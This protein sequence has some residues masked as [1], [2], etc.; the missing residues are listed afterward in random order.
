MP[1]ISPVAIYPAANIIIYIKV[2]HI[3]P[4]NIPLRRR[5]FPK[6]YAPTYE[7]ADSDAP[8]RAFASPMSFSTKKTRQVDRAAA[9][10]VQPIPAAT[11]ASILSIPLD[12][13]LR[14]L[15]RIKTTPKALLVI[16]FWKWLNKNK[17]DAFTFQ[18]KRPFIHYKALIL[19]FLIS[20][21]LL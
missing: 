3:T 13:I 5:C 14:S 16:I 17:K 9:A 21:F 2:E 6:I 11:A 8:A 1:V 20:L 15:L 7:P 12:H 19:F 10:N 4:P 18:R